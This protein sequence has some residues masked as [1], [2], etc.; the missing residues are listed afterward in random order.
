MDGEDGERRRT[1]RR[2]TSG[3][4]EE[5]EEEGEVLWRKRLMSKKRVESGRGWRRWSEGWVRS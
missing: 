4:E 1:R 5:E 2:G 3:G